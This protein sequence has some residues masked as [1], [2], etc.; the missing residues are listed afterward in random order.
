[1][2]IKW[3]IA[4]VSSLVILVMAAV[5]VMVSGIQVKKVIYNKTAEEL[6]NY[7]DLGMAS[8]EGAYIGDWHVE[9]DQL[10]KGEVLINDNYQVVDDLG[11]GTDILATVFLG[12]TRI[13][14][15]VKDDSGKRAI[16]TKASEEVVN[17]VI[18]G[19]KEYHGTAV[20]AGKSAQTL[21]KPIKDA[22]GKVIGM[23]FVGI[24]NEAVNK[25][26]FNVFRALVIL[27]VI[28][29]VIGAIVTN[30]LG[31]AISKAVNQ[32]ENNISR[33]EEGDF[34]FRFDDKLLYRKDEIGKIARSAKNM[35]EKLSDVLHNIQSESKTVKG[36]S[37]LTR[38]SMEEVHGSIEEIS[39]T[40]EQL[41]AGMEETS[42]STA[43]MNENT[44]SIE[45]EVSSMREKTKSGEELAAEIKRR[46]DELKSDT[47]ASKNRA[48]DIYEKVNRQLRVSI[49]K[50]A[51]IEEVK[52]LSNTILSISG[53][54][55]LLA[56]NAAIEAARAGEA[57]KGFAVV[58]D[59]IRKLA[60][61][62]KEAVSRIN[63]ITM[64][65]SDAVD[66]VVKDSRELLSFVDGQVLNDYQ[67]MVDT[68]ARY[69]TDAEQI[70]Q[71]INEINEVAENLYETIGLMR[72]TLEEI[73]SATDEGAM[74]ATDIAQKIVDIT[75]KA[76][77]VLAR[78]AT[79][80]ASAEKLDKMVSFFKI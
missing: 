65:V 10:F 46:A 9:G 6:Q 74:G 80:K 42:A 45:D 63:E 58:A 68:S 13:S 51:A 31:D 75:G 2:K 7:S 37:N 57:G 19:G 49:E 17:A 71:M 23:W 72:K 69:N 54:T 3:K 21:Y 20:V 56:L 18:K 40:T 79:N 27:A 59:E 70:N 38:N 34:T 52:E 30:K 24:Y 14:T 22:S 47:T 78:A 61:S 64:N 35:K 50:T 73:T 26:I 48:S 36:V 67:N 62:T 32:V 5:T 55:N 16:G 33:M 43:Q 25:D 53:Q 77:D 60:E 4:I 11:N 44:V 1:M 15:N 12:D 39:A 41:S 8:F 29:L 76:E 28:L 66:G